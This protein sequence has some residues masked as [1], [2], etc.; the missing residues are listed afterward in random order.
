[1][2]TQV[3]RQP[4]EDEV[5]VAGLL[6]DIGEDANNFHVSLLNA[7]ANNRT[8][9]VK[10]GDR[11]LLVKRYF[12]HLADTRDR[13]ATELMFLDVAG[14]VADSYVPRVLHSCSKTR[15]CVM[16]WV[17]GRPTSEA[18]FEAK[19]LAAALE[20]LKCLNG[21]QGRML[22][23]KCK[24]ASD[25]GFS[26]GQHLNNVRARFNALHPMLMTHSGDSR[27]QGLAARMSDAWRLIEQRA[28]AN[29]ISNDHLLSEEEMALSPSDFGFHNALEAT[30]GRIVFVDFEYAGWDDP[31][32]LV[33]DFF[34]QV[35]VP[36][37][38]DY[39][40]LFL[41]SV[42]GYIGNPASFRE[43]CRDV[44]FMTRFKWICIVL[45]VFLPNALARRKFSSGSV[46]DDALLREQ[47]AKAE[48]LLEKLRLDI[49]ALH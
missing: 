15:S 7:G 33:S 26:M 31:A 37:P 19:H 34:C 12:R 49:H 28:V 44:F 43:R 10:V 21:P 14:A 13:M 42:A 40:S 48:N 8:F 20:F 17:D 29:M 22:G 2:N 3:M 6:Y 23:R 45:N 1:M 25:A 41:D 24:P 30:D 9:K 16:E 5:V 11:S 47:V 36:V 27:V 18:G 4:N 39:M 46:T 32:K 38:M 35:A